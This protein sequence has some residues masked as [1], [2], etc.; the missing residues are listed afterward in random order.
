MTAQV[1]IKP[2]VPC[3]RCGHIDSMTVRGVCQGC[4]NL[5][6][7]ERYAERRREEHGRE[8]GVGAKNNTN[9]NAG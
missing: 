2:I 5:E 9:G 7:N 6:N 1:R 8:V 3:P 4:A